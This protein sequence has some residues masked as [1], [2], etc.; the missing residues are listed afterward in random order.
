MSAGPVSQDELCLPLTV[1]LMCSQA[2]AIMPFIQSLQFFNLSAAW[3]LEVH[4]CWFRLWPL[5]AEIFLDYLNLLMILWTVGGKIPCI[6]I[7]R[8]CTLV[9][10]TSSLL[11]NDTVPFITQ[12]WC[13][14]RLPVNLLTCVTQ[15]ASLNF[16]WNWLQTSYLERVYLYIKQ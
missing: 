16:F 3:R 11:V 2:H 10:L 13:Y 1:F 7:L 6:S 8:N 5:H 4:R 9:K 15:L 12:S 14:H